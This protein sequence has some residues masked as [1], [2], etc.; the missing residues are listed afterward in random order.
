MSRIAYIAPAILVLFAAARS[1]DVVADA[2]LTDFH[3][4][5]LGARI[6][7]Q[8]SDVYDQTT[9][10]A[11]VRASFAEFDAAVRPP[12]PGSFG[13]P[14]WTALAFLPLAALPL[15]AATALCQVLVISG[16]VAGATL[17]LR[18]TDAPRRALPVFLTLVLASQPFIFTVIVTNLGGILLFA[19]AAYA[20]AA[21][22]ARE[23]LSGL[24]LAVLALK[25]HVTAV[26]I[27]LALADIVVRRRWR[28]FGVAAG[29]VGVLV[30][31]SLAV[32]PGWPL[33]WIE[34]IAGRAAPAKGATLT[35]VLVTFGVDRMWVLPAVVLVLAAAAGLLVMSPR[36]PVDLVAVGVC[37]SLLI[38]PYAGSHDHM[39]LAPAWARTLAVGL[40]S[41]PLAQ[42]ALLGGLVVAA[43]LLPWALY[44]FALRTRPDEALNGF[45]PLAGFALLG[46]AYA[47]ERRLARR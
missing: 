18:A 36:A 16:A 35:G 14:L 46:L 39:L 4:F 2:Y 13:Y 30:A 8:G 10:D 12:W 37:A 3:G 31:A 20:V 42:A 28:A 45:V 5:W 21:R 15:R 34:L 17:V 19:L 23:T 9:W 33:D 32:R 11:A 1:I 29:T 22:A 27:P 26:L 24:A 25:P 41:P 7:A 44:A 40:R 38:T 6:L 43:S 47:V